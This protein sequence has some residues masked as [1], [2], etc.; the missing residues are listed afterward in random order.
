MAVEIDFYKE[1]DIHS[2]LVWQLVG[3]IISFIFA[4]FVIVFFYKILF[5]G[6][7]NC[8]LPWRGFGIFLYV[9]AILYSLIALAMIISASVALGTMED[10]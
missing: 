2:Q 9:I 7:K 6:P 5:N 8:K 10:K 4:V 1:G 3:S